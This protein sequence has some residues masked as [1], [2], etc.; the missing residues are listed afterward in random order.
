MP[1][2]QRSIDMGSE[3]QGYLQLDNEFEENKNFKLKK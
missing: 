3:G 1:H 2:T